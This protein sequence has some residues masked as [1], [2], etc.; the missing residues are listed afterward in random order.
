[1]AFKFDPPARY[2]PA[3]DRSYQ[4]EGHEIARVARLLGFELMPWQR[5]VVDV[6]TE[7]R[8]I[9]PGES[10]NDR[11]LGKRGY[12]YYEVI[13]TVPRQ[14]GKTTLM[15]PV[16]LHRLMTRAGLSA[17]STAQTGKDAGKRMRDMI[18]I[19]GASALRP[20][21]KPR[22][23]LGSEGLSLPAN[24]STLTRFAPKPDAI[25]GETPLYIDYDEFWKYSGE[26]GTA[27]MGA[28]KPSQVTVRQLSQLW[29]VS[30]M[31]T[32]ASGFMNEQVERGRTGEA[33]VCYVE[34]S[35]PDG[36]DPYDPQTW[37]TFHPALGN[38]I[39]E[40]DLAADISLPYA[41]WMRAYM[42]RQ[43]MTADSLIEA[44]AFAALAYDFEGETPTR[45]EVVIAYEV[46][47]GN[48][49]AVIYGV[50]RDAAGNPCAHVIH[51]APGTV[52][53]ADLVE[54]LA[55]E[56]KPRAIAA[57]DGGETRAITD[58]LKRRGVEVYVTG[59]RDFGTACI[60]L[61]TAARDDKTFRHDGSKTLALAVMHA[62]LRPMG[63]SWR[64]SR[65][66]STGPIAALIACAVGLWAYDHQE[67]PL[68]APFVY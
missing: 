25:H 7:Y 24:G 61:L 47:A 38:T 68:P 67:A 31:G 40:S 4:T 57:D 27:L 19:V 52:W 54:L 48:E 43:T 66:D 17:W 12:R 50:W 56:W 63:D 33:G 36:L 21:F 34:Y 35:M 3:R 30:T 42:N 20:M 55:R 41:E 14:S 51:A 44:E 26:L 28:V 64:F 60:A 15:A 39:G 29:F 9:G 45:S 6:A 16:R 5:R 8:I 2:M 11:H 22:F 59:P 10:E 58:D 53:L 18:T 62:V 23:S 13:I 37:W 46:A 65:K 49:S 32:A 1:M